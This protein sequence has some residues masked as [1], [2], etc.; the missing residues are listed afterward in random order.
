MAHFYF[1]SFLAV[2][3][4]R[5]AYVEG[6][7]RVVYIA[8]THVGE[9]CN[10]STSGYQ[11]ND[12]NCYSVRDL[13][14]TV[15]K[16][17]SLHNN[18]SI[19]FVILGGDV[20]SSAQT[21]E[22]I[23]AK[24]ELDKLIVDY[25]PLL[26]NHDMWS[27]NEIQGD[28]TSKPV[29]DALFA[30]IFSDSFR[31]WVDQFSLNYENKSVWNPIHKV[32]S[33][34]QSW[35]LIYNNTLRG[36]NNDLQNVLFLAPDFSTR[37]KAP[38]PCPGHSP[39]GGCG[40][41]GMAELYNFTGG[42]LD[43]FRYQL[44]NNIQQDLETVILLTHQPFRCRIGVPDWYFCFSKQDKSTMRTIIERAASR[45]PKG[46]D[47]FWGQW[48]GHQHRWFNGT[49]FDEKEFQGFRQWENS[50]VKGDV[51]DS[52]MASSFTVF[53]FDEGAIVGIEKFWSENGVWKSERGT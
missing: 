32:N 41:M 11:L 4:L 46:L 2:T 29:G 49:S 52:K 35:S 9:G 30:S 28:L 18:Q 8:D 3:T 27:Y 21:N 7:T 39:I 31:K 15:A 48:A 38:P 33:T 1:L 12:T 44:E 26:G 5:I 40:V 51:F 17:N 36:A 37:V 34:F 53:T 13:K 50:A 42:T 10:S 22:F 24:R 19:A 16:V 47:L 45:H 25:I 6:L 14:R 20:T 43:W 23:A